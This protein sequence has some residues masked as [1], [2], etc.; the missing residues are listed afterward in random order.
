M[1]HSINDIRVI[2]VN[3][4]CMTAAWNHHATFYLDGSIADT[5]AER[6]ERLIYCEDMI[7][8]LFQ[9][10][11][12]RQNVLFSGYLKNLNMENSKSGCHFEL[13]IVGFTYSMDVIEKTRVFQNKDMTYG[14]IVTEILKP[15]ECDILSSADLVKSIGQILVQYHETDWE[16]LKR[17]ASHFHMGLVGNYS[18]RNKYVRFGLGDSEEICLDSAVYNVKCNNQLCEFKKRNG[19]TEIIDEDSITYECT[20]T[21]HYNVGA[22]VLF[23]NK[24]TLYRQSGNAIY[25]SGVGF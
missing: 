15:Y 25:R 16:F 24:K 20:D 2:I 11:D 4:A 13:S 6:L 21:R 19:V 3:Q 10:Q 7:D 1:I 22:A 23:Q 14:Q 12:G 5:D 17:L 18:N 8:I 9:E